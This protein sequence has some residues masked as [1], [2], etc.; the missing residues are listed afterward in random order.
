MIK[1]VLD[2]N[3]L[4][5]GL[6]WQGTPKIILDSHRYQASYILILSPEIINEIRLKLLTKFKIAPKT[7]KIL[8]R[9][10]QKYAEL[11]TPHYE[12]DICRDKKD[13]MILDTAVSG[14]ADYIVTGDKDLL[15]LEKFQ[16]IPIVSPNK[17]SRVIT[18]F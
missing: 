3:V 12:T 6:F 1:A 11:V 13:N 8:I 5:S 14:R 18:T 17:F 7:I 4:I 2:T 15:T 9:E 16:K 10:I